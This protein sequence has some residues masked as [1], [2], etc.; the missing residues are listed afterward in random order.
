MKIISVFIPFLMAVIL[1][2]QLHGQAAASYDELIQEAVVQRG[3]VTSYFKDGVYYLEIP[4]TALNRDLIW[5]A[6]ISRGP[7]VQ[8]MLGAE[9]SPGSMID[10]RVVRL[11]RR[12]NKIFVRDYSAPLDLRL[13][14]TA[15]TGTLPTVR[16][17]IFE[18]ALTETNLPSVLMA[19]PIVAESPDGGA[20]VNA[21]AVF[22]KDLEQFNA[23]N[24]FPGLTIQDRL[25]RYVVAHEVGH[26]IGLRH[27]HR[28]SQAYTTKQLR[29]PG[30]A[31]K[32]G[33]VA[34]IMSYGRINYVAQP[35][36]GVTELA[37]KIGPYDLLAVKYGYQPIPGA[38]NPEAEIPTLNKWLEVQRRDDILLWGAE[39]EAAGH[40]P[41]VLT[42]NIGRDRIEA[43][44]LGLKNLQRA[45]ENLP[46]AVGESPQKIDDLKA[47]FVKHLKNRIKPPTTRAGSAANAAPDVRG[48]ARLV[49]QELDGKLKL[50]RKNAADTDTRA[51]LYELQKEIEEVL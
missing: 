45:V 44:E 14:G 11:E 24:K 8:G 7:Y 31:N 2:I 48:A 41:M 16:R 36:D 30:F 25:M 37:P 3:G 42:G 19:F 22:S 13:A 33:P 35:G 20:V 4:Q 23:K 18:A 12:N 32:Y 49:L 5:Y 10:N 1:P 51:H 40:D 38:Y 27:N 6:E 43:T 39:D 28:A 47:I 46:K 26:S 9:T 29:D 50:A 17:S 21:S 15:S 34:S